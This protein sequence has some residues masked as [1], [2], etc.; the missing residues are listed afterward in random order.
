MKNNYSTLITELQYHMEIEQWNKKLR[1]QKY[2]E[3][4]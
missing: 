2:N 1:P 3:Y 4:M